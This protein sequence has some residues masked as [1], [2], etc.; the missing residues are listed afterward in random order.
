VI[1]FNSVDSCVPPGGISYPC[2]FVNLEDPVMTRDKDLVRIR[3]HN[4]GRWPNELFAVF[5]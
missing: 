4:V 5:V 1:F 2:L 3:Q